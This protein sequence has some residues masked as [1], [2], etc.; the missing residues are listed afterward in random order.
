[1][2]LPGFS[3]GIVTKSILLGSAKNRSPLF[4]HVSAFVTASSPST[5]NSINMCPESFMKPWRAISLFGGFSKSSASHC[6]GL[7]RV[8]HKT[9][10]LECEAWH[11]WHNDNIGPRSEGQSGQVDS[12]CPVWFAVPGLRCSHDRRKYAALPAALICALRSFMN[13]A[14]AITIT[15]L[16]WAPEFCNAERPRGVLCLLDAQRPR[17]AATQHVKRSLAGLKL[18]EQTFRNEYQWKNGSSSWVHP[19]ASRIYISKSS[20]SWR[21]WQR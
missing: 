12:G 15:L 14:H 21:H 13:C 4:T 8:Q 20:A 19:A 7:C 6:V 1:M 9:P 2:D 5:K 3:G 17:F 10:Q 16:W 18:Q 11:N